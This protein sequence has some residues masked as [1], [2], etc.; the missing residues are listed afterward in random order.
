MNN[1]HL[2]ERLQYAKE[3]LQIGNYGRVE[4]AANELIDSSDPEFVKDGL[5]YKGMSLSFQGNTSESIQYFNQAIETDPNFEFAYFYRLDNL[6]RMGQIDEA[7]ADA[8]KLLSLDDQNVLYYEKLAAIDMEKRDFVS[9][10]VICDKVLSIEPD[11]IPFISLRADIRTKQKKY[12]LAI[13]DYLTL[14]ATE[15]FELLEP[16]GI[17]I[18]TGFAYLNLEDYA[19]AR[20]HL[21]KAKDLNP[22]HPLALAYLGYSLTH[23]D[24]VDNGVELINDSIDIAPNISYT[25]LLLAKVAIV[26][27][28]M[29]D[30][31]ECIELAQEHNQEG[32]LSEE[33]DALLNALE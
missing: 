24:E 30:A 13:E 8:E 10:E 14:Q 2:Q 23:L 17:Y 3:Q 16:T 6:F 25:Y 31:K 12:A 19:N 21:E 22:N 18:A 9:A 7:R 15:D 27:N 4:R 32:H 5:L 29:E 33:I 28:E 26:L 1:A 11:N 20:I